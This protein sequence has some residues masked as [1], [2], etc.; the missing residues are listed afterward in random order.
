VAI[1]PPASQAEIDLLRILLNDY[2]EP[3]Q[4]DDA[5]LTLILSLAPDMRSAAQLGWTWKAVQTG[6]PN[7]IVRGQIGNESFE[8][9]SLTELR[10]WFDWLRDR[11]DIALPGQ[12]PPSMLWM[13]SADTC[14]YGVSGPYGATHECRTGAGCGPGCYDATRVGLHGVTGGGPH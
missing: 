9:P 12:G 2:D 6:D 3:H 5:A 8:F 13:R 11:I 7:R 14:F 4:F 1:T 10:G